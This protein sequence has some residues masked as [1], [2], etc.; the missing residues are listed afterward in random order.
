MIQTSIFSCTKLKG[1]GSVHEK[2]DFWT[3]PYISKLPH[4]HPMTSWFKFLFFLFQGEQRRYWVLCLWL[5]SPTSTTKMR[6]FI[7]SY[8][9]FYRANCV[10]T[11]KGNLLL[12]AWAGFILERGIA[13]FP[14]FGK[15]CHIKF[16]LSRQM[17]RKKMEPRIN[18]IFWNKVFENITDNNIDLTAA[19]Y[20]LLLSQLP[21]S[22]SFESLFRQTNIRDSAVIRTQA[23]SV[24]QNV[25]KWRQSFNKR[26]FPHGTVCTNKFKYLLGDPLSWKRAL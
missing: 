13:G 11:R 2:I 8:Y 19:L 18:A 25:P 1:L 24:A 14:Q 17:G 15:K 4:T 20:S 16:T 23:F 10:V 5:W 6:Y 3:G 7:T 12:D 26:S 22:S 9:N 21:F